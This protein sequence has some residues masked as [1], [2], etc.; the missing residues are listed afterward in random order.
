MKNKSTTNLIFGGLMI[1]ALV[2][3]LLLVSQ[4]QNTQ[5]GA[6]FAGTK[7]LLQPAEKTA[8]LGEP[9][10]VQ[11]WLSTE[12]KAKLSSVDTTICY[13]AGLKI[14][15]TKPEDQVIL[16]TEALKD[17]VDVSLLKINNLP[18]VRIIAL[19]GATMKPTDLKFGMIRV[20]N[21]KFETT[22]TIDRGGIQIMGARSKIGGY[23][24]KAGATD[25]ALKIG[26]VTGS[27][28]V[29]TDGTSTTTYCDANGECAAGFECI[30]PPSPCP[31]DAASGNPTVCAFRPYCAPLGTVLNYKV[32]FSGVKAASSQCV[33][34]WPLQFIVLGGGVSKTYTDVIPTA[35]TTVGDKLVF[36]G[37]LNLLGFNKT[38]NVAAFVKGPKHLQVKYG[39]N[40]QAGPYNK[41]GGEL[42]LTGDP[43]TSV[44]YD[45]SNYSILAGDVIGT[46]SDAQDGWINGVD[47][48]YVKSKSLVHET[49]SNGGYLKGDLDGN[50]Q[51]NS[52]DVN[53]LKIS[54]QDKQ[55]ELY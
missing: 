11:L 8:K 9:L 40:D 48:S 45:F 39:I 43:A 4:N 24:T 5:R 14:N 33:V 50:C 13:G 31:T 51:V 21:I 30:K 15:V 23:N 27:K 35:S 1:V 41:A 55:G 17:L 36:T 6:Y 20:A 22:A 38:N 32:S 28:Y 53:Q 44:V 16:N 49:V 29:I 26:T 18:C 19:A 2:G 52:N 25:T 34:A 12:G 7:M 3:G 42:V 54:L 46:T 10:V 37:S 47:F